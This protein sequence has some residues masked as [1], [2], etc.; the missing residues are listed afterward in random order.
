[1]EVP[2]HLLSS[3]CPRAFPLPFAQS[4][5]DPALYKGWWGFLGVLLGFLGMMW[6]KL[7]GN[8]FILSMVLGRPWTWQGVGISGTTTQSILVQMAVGSHAV[9]RV[10]AVQVPGSRVLSRIP[11]NS[12][13]GSPLGS[14]CFPSVSFGEGREGRAK[15]SE[16]VGILGIPR[17]AYRYS[18]WN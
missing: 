2:P 3:P 4:Q 13:L 8:A 5:G 9:Q 11:D 7:Q 12:P 16:I 17:G 15:H 6:F 18:R 10:S 14:Q 1:M